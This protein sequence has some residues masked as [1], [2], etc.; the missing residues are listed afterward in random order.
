MSGRWF[1]CA[2]VAAVLPGILAGCD[3]PESCPKISPPIEVA[4][5]Q[6]FRPFF[7]ILA[8]DPQ[9]GM[10]LGGTD[11]DKRRFVELAHQANELDPAFVLVAGD[12]VQWQTSREWRAFDESLKEFRC[13]TKLVVGNHDLRG[14]FWTALRYYRLH[15]GDDYYVFT[16]NNC[17]FIALNSTVLSLSFREPYKTE[18]RT[19]WAWLEKALAASKNNGRTHVFIFMH[20]PPFMTSEDEYD[21]SSVWEKQTRKRLLDLA[22]RY[23]VKVF[24]CGHIHRSIEAKVNGLEVYTVAGTAISWLPPGLGYRIFRVYADRVEQQFVRLDHP[25]DK[26]DSSEFPGT[27]SR[28]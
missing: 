19:Q 24:L 4:A 12:M 22:R 15:Y 6:E 7:F 23:G 5:K 10:G 8:G 11:A 14:N 17:D 3:G 13:P 25:P 1:G 28:Q 16:H 9:M 21:H 18:A 27:P 2:L 26:F 20:R